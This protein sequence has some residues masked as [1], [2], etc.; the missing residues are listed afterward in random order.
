MRVKIAKW[1]N[2]T[3]VR[4]PQAVVDHLNLRPGEEMDICLR[5]NVVEF[6][7]PGNPPSLE[8]L[9]RL[10][11][12]QEVPDTLDWGPDI[13][14]EILEPEYGLEGSHSIAGVKPGRHGP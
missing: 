7:R 1:G 12:T 14:L 9:Y 11:E 3:A 13:G 2:S 4:I 5:D 10:A 6:A 8:D